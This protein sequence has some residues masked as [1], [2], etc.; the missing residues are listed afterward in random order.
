MEIQITSGLQQRTIDP[1]ATTTSLLQSILEI[2]QVEQQSL[3]RHSDERMEGVIKALMNQ[4]MQKKE[5]RQALEAQVL[6]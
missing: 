3:H 1:V 2:H 6:L 4:L 5:R